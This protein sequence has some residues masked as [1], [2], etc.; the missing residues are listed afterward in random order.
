MSERTFRKTRASQAV[1]SE[2]QKRTTLPLDHSEPSEEPLD[3]QETGEIVHVPSGICIGSDLCANK[4]RLNLAVMTWIWISTQIDYFVINFNLKHMD[5]SIFLNF[6]LAGLAEILAH[7]FVGA[8][9]SKM[10]PR[11]TLI[12]GYTI[13]LCGSIPMIW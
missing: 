12:M 7:I 5:G 4:V 2:V 9:F 11:M 13:C 10:G 1:G 6:S 3:C 8:F